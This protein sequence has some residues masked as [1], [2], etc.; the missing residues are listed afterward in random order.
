MLQIYMCRIE[1]CAIDCA[2]NDFANRKFHVVRIISAGF[3]CELLKC[4]TS[5]SRIFI[6]LFHNTHHQSPTLHSYAGES[7]QMLD[8]LPDELLVQIFSTKDDEL[9]THF[10]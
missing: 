9:A 10:E 5:R 2:E 6:L 8:S 4:C 7:L 3:G 1:T